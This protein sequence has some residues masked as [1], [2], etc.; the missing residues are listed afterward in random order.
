MRHRVFNNFSIGRKLEMI[1]RNKRRAR[2]QAEPMETECVDLGAYDHLN[3][4]DLIA[5]LEKRQAERKLGL[6]WERSE[7]EHD[8]ALA[9]GF[10]ALELDESQSVGA[11]PHRNLIIEGD[12]F[13]ALRYL[14]LAYKGRVKCI[15]IDPPYNTGNKD[16]IY[17]DRFLGSDDAYRHSKWLEF[18]Y[19][20]LL[21]AKDL[22]AEDGVLL[23]SI[24]DENRAKL[25]LLLDQIFY[26][27]RRGS[28]VWR[29]RQGSNNEQ[30]CFLSVDHEHVLVYSGAQFQFLG[31][32][33][34][35]EMYSNPD[36][37]PRGE[38][39]PDNLTKGHTYLER[40][41]L[42]YPLVDP[43][44]GIVYPPSPDRVW[45][46]ASESRLKPGQRVQTETME[47]FTRRGQIL[48]PQEQRIAT[49]ATLEEL[50][51]AIDAGD[52]PKAGKTP[53]LRRELPE[54]EFWVGKPVGF[55]RPAFKRFKADLRNATQ[56]ISSW[57]VPKAE[58]DA[59]E[60]ENSFISGTN[61]E[62]ATA[63]A[64]IMG[65]KSFNY[66]KP[67]S[68]I[69]ELIAQA[70]PDKTGL[71]LDFFAGSGTTAQAVLELNFADGGD[72]S[73]I[74]VSSTEATEKEPDK[75]IC[76]DVCAPRVSG[77]IAG[78]GKQAG[79]GGGFAYL[80]AQKLVPE[81]LAIDLRHDQIWLALQLIH[82]G[83]VTPYDPAQPI[84]LLQGEDSPDVLYIAKLDAAARRK[85]QEWS[86]AS[87]PSAVI[88][89]WQ[90]GL[91]R[92]IVAFEPVRVE[93][94]PEYLMLRF[95]KAVRP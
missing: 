91:V 46:Y 82:S 32:E 79:T 36:N 69:K 60:A 88:Y 19:W 16:F 3:K 15:Y 14:Q 4:A 24:N 56:P 53:I 1:A 28:F 54:L 92:Q 34:S 5:L 72:R 61:Q 11:A 62:G 70:T 23:V 57:I 83:T 75:N 55:G 86:A 7:I 77:V 59:Y 27:M 73:F 6:V 66:P 31:Y 50:L 39:R 84:Q 63:L 90:P 67:P 17:N 64:A 71:V 26:G 65:R 33:K 49:W 74:M 35:F 25:E 45:V 94:I 41:N 38:W 42:Y 8:Q 85:L 87:R 80:R 30:D 9:E 43:Q 10:V 76:R 20:R 47:E 29:T 51:A 44:T 2:A 93:K 68:L 12:N 78:Y 52:V 95:G 13:D 48:F 40:P 89:S 81:T 21:L 22:L 37:D 18:L 58:A